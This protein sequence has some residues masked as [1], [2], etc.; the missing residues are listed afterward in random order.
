MLRCSRSEPRSTRRA[1]QDDAVFYRR[2]RIVMKISMR[3]TLLAC[4]A[5]AL[6]APLAMWMS[7]HA[8]AAQAQARMVPKFE[9]D[10]SWPHL[11]AKWVFGQV[12]SISIDENGHAWILQ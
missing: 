4:A 8:D 7:H 10:P 12:S 5:A 2:G 9:V 3:R 6:L 1:P 11:P